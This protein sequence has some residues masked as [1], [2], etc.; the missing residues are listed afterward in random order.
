[1]RT[2]SPHACA[3][4]R[5]A[6]SCADACCVY[7]LAS[8]GG[9]SVAVALVQRDV[10]QA[11]ALAPPNRPRSVVR[12]TAAA[13][14]RP[15]PAFALR[16]PSARSSSFWR[17]RRSE[18][19]GG[20]LYQLVAPCL[21]P[22]GRAVRLRLFS[23]RRSFA[24]AA[25]HAA[26][27]V[28]FIVLLDCRLTLRVPAVRQFCRMRRTM[29]YALACAAALLV[30][31]ASAAPK[32]F[33]GKLQLN[34]YGASSGFIQQYCPADF[35][36]ACEGA[37]FNAVVRDNGVFSGS[38]GATSYGGACAPCGCAAGHWNLCAR[39]DAFASSQHASPYWPTATRR[40]ATCP[41]LDERTLTEMEAPP[42]TSTEPLG[43]GLCL[44][45][46]QIT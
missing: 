30:L 11:T 8:A 12:P 44:P 3:A 46:A 16:G 41:G 18:H 23:F 25:R 45:T 9:A 5:H 37:Q 29:I 24:T 17:V 6:C 1:M 32:L 27:P 15:R 21:H 22:L 33:S 19:C 7:L 28:A 13:H 36:A 38:G 31:P 10:G 4:L 42:R 35:Q 43:L 39:S 14:V 34:V 40:A 20:P 26:H 2:C